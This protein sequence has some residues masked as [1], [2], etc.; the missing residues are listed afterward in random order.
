MC[1]IRGRSILAAMREILCDH[2]HASP[3]LVKCPTLQAAD[4]SSSATEW[5]AKKVG[6][7]ALVRDLAELAIC[8]MGMA[9]L[10]SFATESGSVCCLGACSDDAWADNRCAT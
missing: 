4:S 5:S 3:L 2:L 8:Q 9:C 1:Q 6:L 7:L 10:G